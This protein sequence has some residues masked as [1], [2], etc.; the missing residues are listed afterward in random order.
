MVWKRKLTVS[1]ATEVGI[2]FHRGPAGE[3]GRG[4]K[5]WSVFL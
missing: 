1:P 2:F 5:K 4:L 3:P